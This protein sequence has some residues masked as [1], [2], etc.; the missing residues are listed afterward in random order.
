MKTSAQKK[1][2]AAPA[3]AIVPLGDVAQVQES[4]IVNATTQASAPDVAKYAE[5][6]RAGK[7]TGKCFPRKMSEMVFTPEQ[8]EVIRRARKAHKVASIS[9]KKE[10][11][12]LISARDVRTVAHRTNKDGLKGRI[13]YV[14]EGAFLDKEGKFSQGLFDKFIEGPKP[15]AATA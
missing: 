14:K 11:I 1:E 7:P 12:K 4:G 9:A 13:G 3:P 15:K 5:L 8:R 6:I 10:L 2:A